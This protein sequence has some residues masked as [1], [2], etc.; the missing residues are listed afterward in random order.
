MDDEPGPPGPWPLGDA[1]LTA[2]LAPAIDRALASG[3]P[4]VINVMIESIPS[5]VMRR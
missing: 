2:D 3:K 5:P 1:A 4:A